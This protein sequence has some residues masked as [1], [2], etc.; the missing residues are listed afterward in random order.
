M[1][2][3]EDDGG[4]GPFTCLALQLYSDNSPYAFDEDLDKYGD[5]TNTRLYNVFASAEYPPFIVSTAAIEHTSLPDYLLSLREQGKRLKFLGDDACQS[6]LDAL[7]ALEVNYY[8]TVLEELGLD[9]AENLP[10]TS[11]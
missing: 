8:R 3:I 9:F 5:E 1:S 11:P 2:S 6:I 10:P 4:D 7:P